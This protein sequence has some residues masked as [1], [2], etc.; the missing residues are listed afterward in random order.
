MLDQPNTLIARQGVAPI[1]VVLLLAIIVHYNYGWLP[2][3]GLWLLTLALVFFF[4]D[5]RRAVP[6]SPLAIVA[7]VDGKIVSVDK[8]QDPYLQR[9]AW[10]IRIK[11]SWWGVFTVRSVME[12]KV[13]NQWFGTLPD[14]S[15]SNIYAKSGI[16]PFAQ[17]T[18]SD[19]DDDVVTTLSPRF[20]VKGS[21]CYVQSGERIGQGK[22][23]SYMPFGSHAETFL[24]SNS[25]IDVNPGDAVKAGSSVIATLMH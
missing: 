9:E 11:G 8:V 12:G 7:P 16:P 18:R 19:E 5:P 15:S 23:C 13:Q 10:C 14:D 21:R 3:G 4:R 20:G 1:A 22:R 17:W 2:A 25:R 6:P 24:P